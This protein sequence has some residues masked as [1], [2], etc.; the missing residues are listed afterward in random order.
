M[1]SWDALEEEYYA[2]R[3]SQRQMAAKVKPKKKKKE[4]VET[5]IPERHE[6]NIGYDSYCLGFPLKPQRIS[7]NLY[8]KCFAFRTIVLYIIISKESFSPLLLMLK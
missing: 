6:W 5:L 2:Q 3:D 8:Q 4:L 1:I 7:H